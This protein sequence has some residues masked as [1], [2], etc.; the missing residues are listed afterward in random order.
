M[1]VFLRTAGIFILL[2]LLSLSSAQAQQNY[3]V[4]VTNR[5]GFTIMYIYVSPGDA[6]SWEDDV[7]GMDVLL[8]GS[9]QRVNLYGYRSPIFDIRLVDE[10]GDTYTFWNVDVS[11]QDLVVT[12]A[13]LD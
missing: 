3:Y 9:T 8:S 5:T 6:R 2:G 13:D 11:R 12:L 1:K 4:D 7:L 10:D